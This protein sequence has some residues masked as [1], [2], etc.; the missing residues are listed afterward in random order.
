MIIRKLWMIAWELWQHRN[1]QEHKDD[2]EKEKAKIQRDVLQEIHIG[3][4]HIEE[5]RKY[6]LPIELQKV[7]GNN[8]AYRALESDDVFQPGMIRILLC[9]RNLKIIKPVS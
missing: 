9:S 8:I 2:V 7:Q 4:G 3:I 5:L 6:F 1:Q